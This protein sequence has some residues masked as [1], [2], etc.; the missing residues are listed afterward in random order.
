MAITHAYYTFF[1]EADEM[2]YSDNGLKMEGTFPAFAMF[3]LTW[4]VMY[5]AMGY[6]GDGSSTLTP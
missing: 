3:L 4:I 5:T 1:V 2:S 6:G